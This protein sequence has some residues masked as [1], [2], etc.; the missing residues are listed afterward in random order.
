[1]TR[2]FVLVPI[3]FG[4]CS[5]GSYGETMEGPKDGMMSTDDRDVCATRVAPASPAHDHV[6]APL[7][8]RS[9]TGCVV[10]GCH[11]TGNTGAN[12]PPFS[13][14]GTVYKDLNGTIPNPGVVVRLFPADGKKSVATTVTD[15]AGN[16]SIN[17]PALTAFPYKTDVTACDSDTVA[18]GIRPM[19]GGILKQEMNCN[20]GNTCHQA[21]PTKTAT[22]VYLLD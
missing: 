9:G 18:K 19:V 6:T 5:V 8:P 12:A 3:L 16:F 17:D 4:A 15:A 13:I 11:L 20:A 14:A 7:G 21:S 2:T 1:M 10:A 22:P